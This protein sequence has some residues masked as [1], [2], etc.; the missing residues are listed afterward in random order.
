M[1]ISAVGF[2]VPGP[3]VMREMPEEKGRQ[4]ASRCLSAYSRPCRASSF[5]R[6]FFFHFLEM[7]IFNTHFNIFI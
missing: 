7:V 6:F 3:P 1:V 5:F 4:M 2:P